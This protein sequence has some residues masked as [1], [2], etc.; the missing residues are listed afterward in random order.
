[1][2]NH[3]LRLF[4]YLH[5]I[6]PEIHLRG[7]LRSCPM[8]CLQI[9]TAGSLS[10]HQ[11]FKYLSSF[12]P[13]MFCLFPPMF[14]IP[15]LSF[16]FYKVLPL[17]QIN[18]GLKTYQNPLVFFLFF[19]RFEFLVVRVFTLPH[20]LVQYKIL[21]LYQDNIISYFTDLLTIYY[22]VFLCY[23]LT[24]FSSLWYCFSNLVH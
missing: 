19:L 3:F 18:W 24:S 21:D 13:P 20:C 2:S 15:I 1:M 4:I 17:L 7:Y 9:D 10:F 6:P 23:F 11:C 5:V 16:I 22:F 12:F 8:T 14:Q